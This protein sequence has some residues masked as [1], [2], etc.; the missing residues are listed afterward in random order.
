MAAT[1]ASAAGRARWPHLDK[2]RPAVVIQ[3]PGDIMFVPSGW[4][5]EVK[6]IAP[7]PYLK[8]HRMQSLSADSRSRS[9][10]QVYGDIMFVPS[11]WYHEVK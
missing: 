7:P 10:P 2:A 8:T 4:Y 11:G 6:Y 5:H 3:H 9:S 1:L